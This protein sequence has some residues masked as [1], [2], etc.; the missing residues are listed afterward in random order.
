M[1]RRAVIL[2]ICAI[3]ACSEPLPSATNAAA[4]APTLPVVDIRD[5]VGIE[6]GAP[7]TVP[8]CKKTSELGFPSYAST[9]VTYPCFRDYTELVTH[10]TV[11]TKPDLPRGP[12]HNTTFQ[13]ELGPSAVP[14][15]VSDTA[16]IL[17]ID[18]VPRQVALSTSGVSV[19]QDILALLT[20]KYGK[21]SSLDI[22]HLQN[23]MG[24][25]YESIKASWQLATMRVIFSGM[26]SRADGGVILVTTPQS[27]KWSDERRAPTAKSF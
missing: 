12:E 10:P 14:P 20:A 24:A 8:E 11:R 13:V 3:S 23:A 15:G 6:L 2:G 22:D 16:S 21:P 7:L 26:V 17:M 5:I 19:Q 4:P 1:I 27:D 25:Q 9:G 18:G